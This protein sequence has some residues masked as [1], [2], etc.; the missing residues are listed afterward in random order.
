ME[1]QLFDWLLTD[2]NSIVMIF[3]TNN[4]EE[5][6]NMNNISIRSN[7][8]WLKGCYFKSIHDIKKRHAFNTYQEYI[9]NIKINFIDKYIRRYYRLINILSTTDY[10]LFMHTGNADINIINKLIHIFKTK[11]PLLNFKIV[12]YTKNKCINPYT[13]I[14]QHYYVIDNNENTLLQTLIKIYNEPW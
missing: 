1:T 13:K 11:Y 10:L 5:L 3:E 2:L 9:N 6:I 14:Y 7:H 4:I 8:V 12:S